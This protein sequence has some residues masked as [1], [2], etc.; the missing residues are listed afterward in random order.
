MGDTPELYAELHALRAELSRTK[1]QANLASWDRNPDRSG[2]YVTEEEI[3][4][5]ARGGYQQGEL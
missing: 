3:Y 4:R 1:E 5:A 2:G